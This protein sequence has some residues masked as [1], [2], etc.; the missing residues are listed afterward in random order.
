MSDEEQ[1]RDGTGELVNE[2]P[3]VQEPVQEAVAE[4]ILEA[5]PVKA[6]SKSKAK[7]NIKITKEPAEP[8]K[9]KNLNQ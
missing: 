4:T 6:K 3:P 2:E 9:V 5:K 1:T 7:P 8:I